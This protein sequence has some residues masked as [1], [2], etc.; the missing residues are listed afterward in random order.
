MSELALRGL[1]RR[2]VEKALG[3]MR[4]DLLMSIL[5]PF[6]KCLCFWALSLRHVVWRCLEINHKSMEYPQETPAPSAESR[7]LR[8]EY[9]A[10][11]VPVQHM[12]V[13][14][15]LKLFTGGVTR[16]R[17]RDSCS[18][19]LSRSSKTALHLDFLK[20]NQTRFRSARFTIRLL[21]SFLHCPAFFGGLNQTFP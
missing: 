10:C 19:A 18:K 8:T 1:Q 20:R 21:S 4:D 16:L 14:S 13:L 2:N 11:V 3:K 17:G 7:L 6:C 15:Y 5:Y 12:H 9:K